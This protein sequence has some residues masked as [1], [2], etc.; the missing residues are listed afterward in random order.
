[1]SQFSKFC[2]LFFGLCMY[3]CIAQ[4]KRY[5]FTAFGKMPKVV[6]NELYAKF[7]KAKTL[8]ERSAYLDTISRIFLVTGNADSLMHYGKL[9][10]NEALMA[11]S[12]PQNIEDYQKSAM[13][14]QG[15]AAQKMGL[16]DEA[17]S[18]FIQGLEI[19]NSNAL[20]QNHLKLQL[21]Q[22]YI[23][24][25]QLDKAEPILKELPQTKMP[26]DFYLSNTIVKS[27]FLIVVGNYDQAKKMIDSALLEDFIDDYDKAKLE[28]Q[29]NLIQ[30]NIR[31]GN[32]DN[33]ITISERIKYD[34]LDNDFYDIYIES[35]LN[36]GFAYARTKNYDVAEMAL[37]S[38]YVNTLQWNRLELQKKVINALVKLYSAKKDY[39]NAYALITQYQG[40]SRTIRENQNQRVIKDLELKYETLQKEKAISQL[41]ED[42]IL[43]QA[44]IERQK[45]IKYAFLIG[46]LVILIP[47]ILLLVLYYQKLQT[48]SLLNEQQEAIKEQEMKSLLQS[49]ELELAKNAMS[50]QLK[51]RDRI[52]RELHD[53]IGGNLAGIKLKM[54][55]TNKDDSGFEQILREL[56]TTYDQVREISHS[57]IPK[58]FDVSA[59]TDLV[60]RYIDDLNKDA[61][62]NLEFNAY[63]EQSINS[64]DIALQVALFNIIKELITNALKHANANDIS[65]QVTEYAEDDSI[66]LIYEDDGLGFDTNSDFK[67]IGLSNIES[68]VNQFDG[69]LSINSAKGN[70][71]VISINIPKV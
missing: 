4:D 47:V 70:G 17:I 36:E 53:S 21:A 46:F 34:A 65:I 13:Y 29:L 67:G 44:E 12:E 68:R 27:H 2:F 49:Q 58:S 25:N 33:V 32:Y 14:Y 30:L 50:V 55:S 38:A 62:S 24:K 3:M 23:F 54:N 22:T 59:F 5:D 61:I 10:K 26:E 64:I 18:A 16:M 8:S 52:A 71:T 9:L 39:E 15:V 56:D 69:N 51:E 11:T 48:Q 28:L 20:L 43:K 31:Q 35:T 19:E 6:D 7:D 41:Q 63:P 42:Q 40:V 57:L 1:M 60:K 37:S 66:S 45:T